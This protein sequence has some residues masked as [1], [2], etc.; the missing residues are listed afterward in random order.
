MIGTK[1]MTQN[2]DYG[3]IAEDIV[4]ELL[5][6]EYGK[7]NV[8]YIGNKHKISGDFLIKI[9][10]KE[11]IIEVKGQGSDNWGQKNDSFDSITSYINLSQA[12]WKKLIDKKTGKEFQK[13]FEVWIV[14][15]LDRKLSEEWEV[16]I[17]K[18]SGRELAKC[19]ITPQPM[20]RVITPRIFWVKNQSSQKILKPKDFSK[21]LRRYLTVKKKK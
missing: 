16:S 7:N 9:G 13:K 14:Y 15:R 21:P 10:K 8:E 11:K 20:I 18:I 5:Y 17:T 1:S 3:E 4:K 2:N 19:K 6:K 12:E